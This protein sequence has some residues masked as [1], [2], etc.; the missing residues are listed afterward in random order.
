[1]LSAHYIVIPPEINLHLGARH[2]P[3]ILRPTPIIAKLAAHIY[4][5]FR[6]IYIH[7]LYTSGARH[8]YTWWAVAVSN[9]KLFWE[10]N[11][12]G[13]CHGR[14]TMLI[15][16]LSHLWSVNGE[17]SGESYLDRWWRLVLVKGGLKRYDLYAGKRGMNGW[18]HGCMRI[19]SYSDITRRN[20]FSMHHGAERSSICRMPFKNS[21]VDMTH[22][23]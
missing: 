20:V 3:P 21:S 13:C 16:E 19:I 23:K 9:I 10:N 15:S 4:S 8:V 6:I 17:D 2:S 1:M 12:G 5:P 18:N 14:I 7:H 11:V 22:T